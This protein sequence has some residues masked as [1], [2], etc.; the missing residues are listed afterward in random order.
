MY[1][2]FIA[3]HQEGY[4]LF[5]AIAASGLC[6]GGAPVLKHRPP[7]SGDAMLNDEADSARFHKTFGLLA[8]VVPGLAAAAYADQKWVDS[9]W[10]PNR[11]AEIAVAITIVALW[12]VTAISPILPPRWFAWSACCL[13]LKVMGGSDHPATIRL[14]P[15]ISSLVNDAESRTLLDSP[16]NNEGNNPAEDRDRGGG[17]SMVS[18]VSRSQSAGLS[19][20]AGEADWSA[21]QVLK[22][23][24]CWLMLW[25]CWTSEGAC[26]Y[27]Q[28]VSIRANF[29]CVYLY[30]VYIYVYLC[31]KMHKHTPCW[32]FVT[33][34]RRI[35]C[36][37]IK[38]GA[39][40]TSFWL[41]VC[42]CVLRHAFNGF[43]GSRQIGMR[44]FV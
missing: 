23:L 1:T 9:S 5:A 44:S 42:G 17:G 25:S 43:D 14:Q 16:A 10:G 28:N 4:V 39:N 35:R 8:V 31:I 27:T 15:A 6:F 38:H 13:K 30:R 2:A 7:A 26:M 11:P 12:V 20:P 18:S 33:I 40:C 24:N 21:W 37:C 36:N 3:P 19:V 41:R 34:L 29:E 32:Y 22:T